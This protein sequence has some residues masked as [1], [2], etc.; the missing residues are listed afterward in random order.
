M[1]YL[2]DITISFIIGLMIVFS[3]TPVYAANINLVNNDNTLEIETHSLDEQLD[4]LYKEIG[5]QL[6]INYMYI[7]M[8]HL[9]AGGK[10]VYADE[11]PNIKVDLT[12]ENI[13][14]AFQIDGVSQDY[15]LQADWIYCPDETIERPNPYYLPDCAYNVTASIIA[16]MNNRY[17]ADRGTMQTYFDALTDE[18]KTTILFCEAILEYTGSSE[19]SVNNFYN[20]YERL[21]FEKE[22]SENI[23]EM[24]SEGNYRFKD[25]FNDIFVNN[26]IYGENELNYLTTILRYDSSLAAYASVDEVSSKITMPYTYGYQSRENM[27]IAAMSVI[28]KVRY[29]WGGGHSG[30][31]D[32]EGINP[33]WKLFYDSYSKNPNRNSYNKCIKP[34]VSWC[35]IHKET[36]GNPNGCL[37]ESS[38]V[39]NYDE[40]I[41]ERDK[42]YN[43]DTLKTDQFKKFVNQ[44]TADGMT[45]HLL[46]GLDCSGYTNWL[47]N[48]VTTRDM[49]FDAGA[50]AFMQQYGIK[51]VEFGSKLLP[52]DVFS[53]GDHI[54]VIIG[55]TRKG[56]NAYVTVEAT[57]CQLKCGVGYYNGAS[58]SDI[59]K[60]SEIAVEANK[61]FGNISEDER[62]NKFNFNAVGYTDCSKKSK[63]YGYHG[64]G[65]LSRPFIDESIILSDYGKTYQELN[66]IE[67]IQHTINLMP[68][69]YISGIDT[70][71][72]D[73]FDTESVI[74]NR[75]SIN[76]EQVDKTKI[77]LDVE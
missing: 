21:L 42:R 24:D 25:K 26:G 17:N 3:M 51:N 13:K 6:N 66:A 34:Y 8:I 4:E 77:I 72:G 35:P 23:I 59:D 60:A 43:T 5:E 47:Y 73:I 18:V 62:I 30:S 39:K 61:L 41:Y 68:Y 53:F 67:I 58:Q 74:K 37:F 16:I 65:R 12:V 29:V 57:P 11:N 64:F 46:D 44:L 75:S 7:K 32:I 70:Y 27:M 69:Q 55:E 63:W 20:I 38:Y 31:G 71:D 15:E 22:R 9:I 48:Q 56:S 10:A 36:D 54:I 28:G 19:N 45:S 2:K 76:T 1:G 50:L 40:F 33:N 52:G 14:P 49:V